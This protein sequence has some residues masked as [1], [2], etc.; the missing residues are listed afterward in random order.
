MD[1]ELAEPDVAVTGGVN[2]AQG[3]TVVDEPKQTEMQNLLKP[4]ILTR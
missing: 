4:N 3:G 1:R 2:L